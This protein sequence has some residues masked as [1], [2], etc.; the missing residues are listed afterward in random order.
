MELTLHANA[1]TTPKTRAYIQ[2]SRA[3]VATLA[4]ELG[5]SE[6]TIRRWRGRGTQA[7]AL[8]SASA[9]PLTAIALDLGYSDP[10]HFTRAFARWTGQSPA[11]GGGRLRGNRRRLAA[12]DADGVAALQARALIHKVRVALD[13]HHEVRMNR[14]RHGLPA[15]C[16]SKNWVRLSLPSC[17]RV[18]LTGPPWKNV[19]PMCGPNGSSSAS[20]FGDEQ[21]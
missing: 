13:Q 21:N 5:V 9:Q 11:A 19:G 20:T 2:R 18:S 12:L 6:T 1:T 15:R 10:A 16:D 17:E 14:R 7:A 3:S 8:I 4:A